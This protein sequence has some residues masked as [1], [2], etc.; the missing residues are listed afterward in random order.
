VNETE[1][2]TLE[3]H[4]NWLQNEVI[5]G[6]EASEQPPSWKAESLRRAHI[7]V[8]N[9][10]WRLATGNKAPVC[11]FAGLY[12]NHDQDRCPQCS[13]KPRPGKRLQPANGAETSET[14]LNDETTL[15]AL[16]IP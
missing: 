13:G 16:Q 12:S 7:Q 4:L 10:K 11:G 5:P 6:F 9:I 14:T 8:A 1:R 3:T 15:P 2:T